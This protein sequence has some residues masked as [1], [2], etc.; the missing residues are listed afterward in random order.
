MGM[1]P[2]LL[3]V[4][5]T[6]GHMGWDEPGSD[7][8]ICLPDDGRSLAANRDR[9][10]SLEVNESRMLSESGSPDKQPIKKGSYKRPLSDLVGTI[11]LEPTTPTMSR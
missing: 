2:P 4:T 6:K 3:V 11:G 8:A 10:Q 9:P 7:P 5:P 1:A